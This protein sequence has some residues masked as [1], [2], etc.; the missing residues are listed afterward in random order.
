MFLFS[1]ISINLFIIIIVIIKI[2]RPY[3]LFNFFI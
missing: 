1:S 3:F 2:Q